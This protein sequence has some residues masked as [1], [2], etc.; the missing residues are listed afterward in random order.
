MYLTTLTGAVEAYDENR[1]L[2]ELLVGA[3]ARLSSVVD[4]NDD[5]ME[6]VQAIVSA[7]PGSYI[8]TSVQN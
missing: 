4:S 5:V 8:L 1:G 2:E 7:G 3:I 6:R